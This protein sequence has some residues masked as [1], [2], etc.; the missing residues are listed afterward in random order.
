MR[1]RTETIRFYDFIGEQP[2]PHDFENVEF[3]A[4]EFDRRLGTPGL[5]AVGRRVHRQERRSILPPDLIH[6]YENDAFWRDPT[7]N[8]NRVRVV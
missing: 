8:P 3:D 6:K 4:I 5:H 7:R 2:F 1:C